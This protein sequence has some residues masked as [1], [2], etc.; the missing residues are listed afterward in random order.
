MKSAA[1]AAA[2]ALARS[3]DPKL[4]IIMHKTMKKKKEKK[5]KVVCQEEHRQ[6]RFLPL[7]P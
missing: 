3:S 1:P 5:K 7:G 2:V 6:S 4:K